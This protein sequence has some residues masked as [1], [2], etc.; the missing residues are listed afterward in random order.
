M[1]YSQTLTGLQQRYPNGAPAGISLEDLAQL[2]TQNTFETHLDISKAMATEM[3]KDMAR[4]D[5]D[6]SKF[7]Q[8][9]G[10]SLIHI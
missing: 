7:T 1:T 10:L 3:R 5:N 9:L 8:S 6:T 4:Y 2:K